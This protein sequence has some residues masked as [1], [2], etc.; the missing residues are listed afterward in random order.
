M[1]TTPNVP[2]AARRGGIRKIFLC[3]CLLPMLLLG[4]GVVGTAAYGWF[5]VKGM[6]AEY[7]ETEP[8]EVPTVAFTDAEA[9]AI[10]QQTSEFFRRVQD[11]QGEGE[12][13]LSTRELN[14]L[15]NSQPTLKDRVFVTLQNGRVHAQVSLP[16]DQFPGG[17]GR[18]LNASGEFEASLDAGQLS[19]NLVSAEIKG[20]PVS[21]D[22][23]VK[24]RELQVNVEESDDPRFAALVQMFEKIKI[25]DDRLVVQARNPAGEVDGNAIANVKYSAPNAATATKSTAAA[26]AKKSSA[27]A[28]SVKAEPEIQL[29]GFGKIQYNEFVK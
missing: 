9:E 5:Y 7:T 14:V 8:R 17:A 16:T 18:Y 2:S 13:V 4:I 22:H 24:L 28:A 26:S 19:L 21:E 25:Q 1:S 11:G 6:V 15:L 27:K 3:G 12:L 29:P 23:L 10:E 20:E